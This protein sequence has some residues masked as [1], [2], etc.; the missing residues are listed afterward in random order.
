MSHHALFPLCPTLGSLCLAIENQAER[1][2]K[3]LPWSPRGGGGGSQ[4]CCTAGPAR[5]SCVTGWGQRRGAL[6]SKKNKHP[7]IASMKTKDSYCKASPTQKAWE[8]QTEFCRNH[9]IGLPRP[10]S[11]KDLWGHRRGS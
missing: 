5:V 3:G 7:Q 9:E 6:D 4:P 11:C 1:E 2:K 10:E 8:A